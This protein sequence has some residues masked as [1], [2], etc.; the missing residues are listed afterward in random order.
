MNEQS[1]KIWQEY[2]SRLYSFIL[3]R[4]N[5]ASIAE[6]I[7]QD[8]FLKIQSK[9]SAL[10]E[11]SK[12]RSWIYQITRN[13]IIDYYRSHKTMGELPASLSAPEKN[14]TDE[15]RKEIGGC[16]LPMIKRLPEKYS[17]ALMLSEIE[18]LTQKE[19]AAR[20]ELTLSGAKSRVQR[21]RAL[22]REMLTECCHFHFDHRGRM[23]DYDGKGSKCDTC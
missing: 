7:L 21:G 23:Y 12:L 15:A 5:N 3:S 20:Q 17:E 4:V 14:L 16:L 19:V 22:M 10:K 18:G 6:D 9:I 1:D 11:N 2:H 8:V 13:S